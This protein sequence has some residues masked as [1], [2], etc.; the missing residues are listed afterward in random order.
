MT[1]SIFHTQTSLIH[2]YDDPYN[3]SL[4]VISHWNT[5]NFKYFRLRIQ[6]RSS[7]LSNAKFPLTH[8]PALTNRI[9][10]PKPIPSHEVHNHQLNNT[11]I[12]IPHPV[13]PPCSHDP[14][15]PV[16]IRLSSSPILPSS[17]TS[18]LSLPTSF[19]SHFKPLFPPLSFPDLSSHRSRPDNL[20]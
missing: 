13:K 10:Y 17:F 12:F 16:T 4:S 8:R 19:P 11:N 18:F 6:A 20:I 3:C 5:P 9:F 15:R 2:S 14:Q 7:L 1:L